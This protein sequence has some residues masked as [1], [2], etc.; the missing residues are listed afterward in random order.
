[1]GRKKYEKTKYKSSKIK[2][3]SKFKNILKRNKFHKLKINYYVNK[4]PHKSGDCIYAYIYNFT[5]NSKIKKKLN[6]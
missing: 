6:N 4:S 5:N 2:N 1:M 3:K